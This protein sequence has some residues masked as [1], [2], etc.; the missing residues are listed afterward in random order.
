M[1]RMSGN[2]GARCTG[3]RPIPTRRGG[4]ECQR[5]GPGFGLVCEWDF[6]LGRDGLAHSL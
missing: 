6:Y 3:D 2:V 5:G 4:A 1:E